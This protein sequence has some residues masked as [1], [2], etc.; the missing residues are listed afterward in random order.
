MNESVNITLSYIYS[1]IPQYG[2]IHTFEQLMT[3]AIF[4]VNDD[5]QFNGNGGKNV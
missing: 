3:F 5:W 1:A 4:T 2:A